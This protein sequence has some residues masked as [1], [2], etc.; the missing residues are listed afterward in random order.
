MALWRS[1][2]AMALHWKY[3]IAIAVWL[4][5]CAMAL[6][7]HNGILAL[8][9]SR[10]NGTAIAHKDAVGRSDGGAFHFDYPRLG[11]N[12]RY[13][14]SNDPSLPR[15]QLS[16]CCG[17]MITIEGQPLESTPKQFLKWALDPRGPAGSCRWPAQPCDCSVF[18]VISRRSVGN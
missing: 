5:R 14:N 9:L 2:R 6:P 8:S 10:H 4:C 18:I 17:R 12:L 1:H 13:P 3:G 16:R 11:Q 7:W 15:L